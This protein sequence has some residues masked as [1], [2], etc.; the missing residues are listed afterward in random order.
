MKANKMERFPTGMD[1]GTSR[2]L[3][4]PPTKA[5]AG[6]PLYKRHRFGDTDD[7]V[8]KGARFNPKTGK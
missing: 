8:S 1:V 6:L 7:A 4:N 3:Q 5:G 2:R